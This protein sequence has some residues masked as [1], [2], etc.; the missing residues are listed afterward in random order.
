MST[1][2]QNKC[3]VTSFHVFLRKGKCYNENNNM[4]GKAL[5][6]S[7]LSAMLSRW[8]GREAFSAH[9]VFLPSLR[10]KSEK[11]ATY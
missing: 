7:N 1:F 9:T 4:E 5:L 6:E 3:P 8:L 2:K 11:L 10:G